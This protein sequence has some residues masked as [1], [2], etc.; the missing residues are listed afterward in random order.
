VWNGEYLRV[1]SQCPSI[2]QRP[3]CPDVSF[4]ACKNNRD[5]D[6]PILLA[7]GGNLL[8]LAHALVVRDFVVVVATADLVLAWSGNS[9]STSALERH[10]QTPRGIHTPEDLLPAVPIWD[11]SDLYCAVGTLGDAE[12]VPELVA[13]QGC[14]VQE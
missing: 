11:F 14:Y 13:V 12:F 9:V 4:A 5:L 3:H 1:Q 8:H 6:S 7:R 10:G 2:R